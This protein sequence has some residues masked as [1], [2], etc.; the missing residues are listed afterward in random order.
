MAGWILLLLTAA[1]WGATGQVGGGTAALKT[2]GFLAAV[3]MA[4]AQRE[5]PTRFGIVG[6]PL[7]AYGT[8]ATLG[9]LLNDNPLGDSLT[10]SGRLVVT[11]AAVLWLTSRWNRTA[12]L[13][14]TA[15]VAA[16]I[17]AAALVGRVLGLSPL[18]NER[19]TGWLPPLGPNALGVT[20]GIGLIAAAVLWLRHELATPRA[21]AYVVTLAPTLLLTQSRTAVLAT[22]IGLVT[23]LLIGR[24]PRTA[25]AL[26]WAALGVALIALAGLDPLAGSRFRWDST[27]SG[28][29]TGW[30]TV[31]GLH[32]EPA[33]TWFGD[34]LAAKYVPDRSVFGGIRPV[35]G[36]W[37]SAYLEAGLIGLGLLAVAVIVLIC[38]NLRA[39]SLVML[40]LL[41]FLVVDA[42]LESVLSDVTFPFV[43]LVGTAGVSLLPRTGGRRADRTRPAPYSNYGSDMKSHL[44]WVGLT[45]VAT[46][47]AV[48]L[49]LI[50]IGG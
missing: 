15:T 14:T 47:A 41:A 38:L 16:G 6:W 21:L 25:A 9:A 28:R 30:D 22:G 35:D 12:L 34:G 39:G 43:V 11:V 37:H 10:R 5:R 2:V 13:R 8:V 24:A 31:V 50:A 19:L 36:T 32:R 27:F 42:T 46:L 3:A 23:A 40:P 17:S 20:A 1:P 48:S 26:Y 29:T 45:A 33:G 4:Y 49:L 44:T 7:I 18:F